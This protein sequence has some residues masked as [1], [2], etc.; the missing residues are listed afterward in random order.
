MRPTVRGYRWTCRRAARDGLLAWVRDPS[1]QGRGA[2]GGPGGNR[3]RVRDASASLRTAIEERP[4]ATRRMSPG[5]ETRIDCAARRA[6]LRGSYRALV[7]GG[8]TAPYSR[9]HARRQPRPA[10]LLFGRQGWSLPI[11]LRDR[12]PALWSELPARRT[13]GPPDASRRCPLDLGRW[14][15]GWDSNPRPPGYEPSGLPAALPRG[16][17][18][19]PS[20]GPPGGAW[21]EV[22][23]AARAQVR[24]AACAAPGLCLTPSCRST[25]RRMG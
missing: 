5:G 17:G 7:Y 22:D 19:P 3:T 16:I 18:A 25:R 21:Q 23:P 4:E 2:S 14:L 13:P 12:F 9:G 15:R 11:A 1:R 24:V 6:H 10:A 8:T 20:G